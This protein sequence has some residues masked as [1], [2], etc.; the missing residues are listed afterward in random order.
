MLIPIHTK[1]VTK[2]LKQKYSK[3]DIYNKINEL[4]VDMLAMF[5]LFLQ[6]KKKNDISIKVAMPYHSHGHMECLGVVTII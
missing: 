5:L 4:Q 1:K 3:Y 2:Y 6:K